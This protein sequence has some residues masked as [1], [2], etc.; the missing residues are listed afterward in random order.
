MYRLVNGGY[1][2]WSELSKCSVTCGYGRQT[3]TRT[4]TNPSPKG[5]G[6][7][8][9]KELGQPQRNYP[10]KLPKCKTTGTI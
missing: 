10:C 5:Y 1:S 2:D 9:C 8:D 3:Q 4:C 7:K 6:A